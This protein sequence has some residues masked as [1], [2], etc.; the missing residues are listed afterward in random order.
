MKKGGGLIAFHPVQHY[1]ALR[2][3]ERARQESLRDFYIT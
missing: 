3:H 1:Q 2:A